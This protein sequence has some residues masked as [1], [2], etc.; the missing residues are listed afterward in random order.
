MPPTPKIWKYFDTHDPTLLVQTCPRCGTPWE[1]S[2]LTAFVCSVDAYAN[3]VVPA[4]RTAGVFWAPASM[5]PGATEGPQNNG[6]ITVATQFTCHT[7]G[8]TLLGAYF[9]K[10]PTDTASTHKVTVYKDSDLSVLGTVTSSGESASGWQHVTF[11]PPIPLAANVAIR[12]AA[13]FSTPIYPSVGSGQ[14][15]DTTKGDYFLSGTGYYAM[16]D[17]PPSQAIGGYYYLIDISAI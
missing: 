8:K 11:T 6:P 12:V 17:A 10:D 13:Y 9:Y 3:V 4:N 16:G 7:S 2:A 1:A 15:P 14:V 5:P